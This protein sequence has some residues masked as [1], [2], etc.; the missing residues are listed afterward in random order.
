MSKHIIARLIL[1]VPTLFGVSFLVFIGMY[2]MP[3]DP[4]M[5][6]LSA[7]NTVASPETM[8]SI[9]QQLGIDDPWHVRYLHFLSDAVRGDLGES[10]RTREDVLTMVASQF[11]STLQLAVVGLVVAFLIGTTLGTL[12][13]VFRGRWIDTVAMVVAMAGVSMP[14][15]WLGLLLLYLFSVRLGWVT[16][17]GSDD[18]KH[19]VLPASVLGLNA[20]AIVSRLT[21]SSMLDVLRSEYVTTARAKGLRERAVVLAHALPNALIP[22]V[23]VVGLQFGAL[24]GG[25]MIIEIVFARQ[26]V[27][28]IAVTAIQGKD[29]PVVQ[30]VVLLVATS[31]VL[32]NL[33]VDI[34]YAFLDPRIRHG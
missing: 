7:T 9:R 30:G 29:F 33:A 12:A 6:M 13:A 3:G 34:L 11:P 26:G 17:T 8:A 27:G 10:W 2:L 32:V 21:R 15:F 19:L 18:L 20:S 4:V 22:T 31:Y 28:Q 24:L 1:L 25:S 5:T 16:I 14:S 23:T